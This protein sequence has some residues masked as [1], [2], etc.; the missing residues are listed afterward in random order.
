MT[1]EAVKQVVGPV[2]IPSDAELT[3]AIRGRGPKR[4]DEAMPSSRQSRQITYWKLHTCDNDCV[5]HPKRKGW[6]TTGPVMSPLT[7]QEWAEFRIIHHAL[8]LDE[9][10]P[11]KYG[12]YEDTM[13]DPIFGGTD[14]FSPLIEQGGIRFFP[15]DQLIQYGW[16]NIDAV[17]KA[18]PDLGNFEYITCDYDC[19]VKPFYNKDG[20]N[21]HLTAYHRDA[22]NAQAVGQQV[23]S[24]MSQILTAMPANQSIDV[25]ELT[26]VIVAAMTKAQAEVK[27]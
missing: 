9:Q 21:R 6:V 16:A 5:R 13:G 11:N 14:R 3:A 22:S 19:G 17:K 12:K 18:R 27:D 1:T 25:N 23:Q 2:Q 15:K 20:Y 8:P 26:K 7:A 4:F 24:A 10:E